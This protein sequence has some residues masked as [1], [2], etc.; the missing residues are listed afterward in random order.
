MPRASRCIAVG[1]PHHVTQRGVDGRETFSSDADRIAYL[2]LLKQNRQDAAVR[3]LAWC[4]MNNHVHLILVPEREDSLAVLLRRTHGRYAQYYNVRSGRT[5]HLWQNRYFACALGPTHLWR[6]LV[7]VERN[8]VRAGLVSRAEQYRWSSARAHLTGRDPLGLLDMDWW[9]REGAAAEWP[10][11]L[12][13]LDRDG[14][15]ELVRCTYAGRPFGDAR[16]VEELAARFKRHWTR[17]RPRK[18][19]RLFLTTSAVPSDRLAI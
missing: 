5:G 9:I 15:Q 17:G 3:V 12:D 11:L 8:P 10:E 13:G 7:Y 16:F 14:H 1:S 4:L 19:Q 6:A 2:E 18:P